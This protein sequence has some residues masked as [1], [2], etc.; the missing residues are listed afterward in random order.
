MLLFYVVSSVPVSSLRVVVWVSV[1]VFYFDNLQSLVYYVNFPFP[2]LV[3]L[4]LFSCVPQMCL[5]CLNFLLCILSVSRSVLCC[6]VVLCCIVPS[7]WEFRFSLWFPHFL[8]PHFLI[9]ALCGFCIFEFRAYN[10]NA[11]SFRLPLHLWVLQLA[12]NLPTTQPDL[13]PRSCVFF[14]SCRLLTKMCLSCSFLL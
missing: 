10:N 11:A 13:T 6:F 7:C 14:L 8:V 5:H 12:P 2:C 3:S 1:C 4:T 9:S